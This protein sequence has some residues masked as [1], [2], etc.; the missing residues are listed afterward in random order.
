MQNAKRMI[1]PV[2]KHRM[3]VKFQRKVNNADTIR[4]WNIVRGDNVWL[5]EFEH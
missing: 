2:I 3:N 5:F 4:T 1:H